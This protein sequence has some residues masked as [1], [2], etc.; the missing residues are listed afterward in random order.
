MV[1]SP[2]TDRIHAALKAQ[3][4]NK[5]AETNP[6]N[7]M[8]SEKKNILKREREEV[9]K[10]LTISAALSGWKKSFR[11]KYLSCGEKLSKWTA[12]VISMLRKKNWHSLRQVEK[13]CEKLPGSADISSL[14]AAALLK[15]QFMLWWFI[16]D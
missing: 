16:F 5:E 1:N 14:T 11:A 3:K 12:S 6:T 10:F 2:V 4:S 9:R 8:C 7:R 13:S 15:K